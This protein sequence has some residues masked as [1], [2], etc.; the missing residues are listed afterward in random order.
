MLFPAS[1]CFMLRTRV[2]STSESAMKSQNA[3]PPF[4]RQD[5]TLN[6]CA[7]RPHP[8]TPSASFFDGADA[9]S[10]LAGT[11]VGATPAARMPANPAA[12]RLQKS[13]LEILLEMLLA[14]L[15]V[16]FLSQYYTIFPKCRSRAHRSIIFRMKFSNPKSTLV[17]WGYGVI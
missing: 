14:M 16:P 17:F 6:V 8:I 13:R 7:M 12:D 15:S 3:L 11:I 9:P 1:F 5:G 4:R 10:T 2:K